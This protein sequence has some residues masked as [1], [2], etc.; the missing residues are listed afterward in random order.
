MLKITLKSSKDTY[1][2]K[3]TVVDA[4]GNT[5]TVNNKRYRMTV[6]G[7]ADELKSYIADKKAEGFPCVDED[8]TVIY[9][10]GVAH[11]EGDVGSIE[12]GFNGGWFLDTSKED[13]QNAIIANEKNPA[14]AAAMANTIAQAR[15]ADFL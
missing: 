3:K 12:K 15:L 8:G 5:R 13:A 2:S 4:A 14:I 1:F 11:N 9:N 7:D 10:T 6:T